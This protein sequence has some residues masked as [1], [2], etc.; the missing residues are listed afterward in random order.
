MVSLILLVIATYLVAAIPVG[1]LYAQLK[2]VN[3]RAQGSGNYGATNIYRAFGLWAAAPVF[4]ADFLKGWVPVLVAQW[5]SPTPLIH[6]A[7]GAVAIAGHPLPVYTRFKGG[8]GAATG[9]G[10]LLGLNPQVF[11]VVAV[12][13]ALMIKLT[14]IV[15]LTTITAC[16]V[17]PVLFFAFGAP[18]SYTVF[19][20]AI[21]LFV[22][23]RH[24]DNITRLRN[25]TENKV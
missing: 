7:V 17:T 1:L 15:S 11:I 12:M 19:V 3:I 6:V 2:N 18:R 21:S 9:L 23:W 20:V 5:L 13:A 16:L 22:I 14:R 25:G 24:R 8:K 10:V 4:L